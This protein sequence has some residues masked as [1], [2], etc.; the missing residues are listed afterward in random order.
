MS[1][2]VTDNFRTLTVLYPHIEC[3]FGMILRVHRSC[4]L[5]IGVSTLWRNFYSNIGSYRRL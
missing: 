5:Y 2:F 1:V 3:V 4:Y